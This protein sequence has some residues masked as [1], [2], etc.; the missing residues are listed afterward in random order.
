MSNSPIGR[1]K[2][3]FLRGATTRRKKRSDDRRS[4]LHEWTA[5]FGDILARAVPFVTL[6]VARKR[7]VAPFLEENEVA[8]SVL[9]SFADRLVC[10]H[11]FDAAVI[12]ANTFPLLDDCVTR[13]INDGV[14]RPNGW[15][16]GEVHGLAAG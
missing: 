15:R 10:R 16:A 6:D 1:G 3:F 2:A 4:D 7:L 14:F 13:L 5:A 9:A 11:V 12:P 8:L